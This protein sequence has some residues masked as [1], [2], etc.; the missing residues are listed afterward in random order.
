MSPNISNNQPL[1]SRFCDKNW[2]KCVQTSHHDFYIIV[3][4]SYSLL[5]L[6]YVR[7]NTPSDWLRVTKC[8]NVFGAPKLFGQQSTIKALIFFVLTNWPWPWKNAVSKWFPGNGTSNFPRCADLPT[9]WWFVSSNS[10]FPLIA[11]P[12]KL[13]HISIKNY[14]ITYFCRWMSLV[15]VAFELIQKC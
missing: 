5:A 8:S 14:S 11:K 4:V 13:L 15:M 10:I 7:Q 12:S 3:K 9:I 6:R 2:V 1:C